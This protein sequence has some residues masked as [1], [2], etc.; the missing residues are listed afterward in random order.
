MVPVCEGIEHL[1][2]TLASLLEQTRAPDD[3]V[4]VSGRT[5]D[6][7]RTVAEDYVGVRVID[8]RGPGLGAAR[9]QGVAEVSGD[10][11]AFCDVD[12][13]WNKGS[14][15]TRLECLKDNSVCHAVIGHLA[16]IP[17]E[18]DTI[19]DLRGERLGWPIPAYTPS[20]LVI[21]RSAFQQM[22]P[23]DEDLTIGTD[24]DWF[25]RLATSGLTLRVLDDIVLYKGVRLNSLSTNIEVYRRDLLKIVHA[26]VGRR[27]NRS[28]SD[29]R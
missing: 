23:F 29:N 9:N 3:I 2:G 16:T 10:V 24:T 22:G 6:A 13:R 14:L 1:P 5:D 8:Q 12:D 15:A 20:A 21:L 7:C 17:L 4:V 28:G 25:V 26:H 19:P 11:I 27:R 18:G